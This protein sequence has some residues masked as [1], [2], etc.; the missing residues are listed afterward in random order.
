MNV[1]IILLMIIITVIKSEISDSLDEESFKLKEE[2]ISDYKENIL[3]HYLVGTSSKPV[4]LYNIDSDY[5]L[6]LTINVSQLNI[7]KLIPHLKITFLPNKITNKYLTLEQFDYSSLIETTILM[8]SD[9]A[10]IEHVL[11]LKPIEREDFRI[12]QDHK[13]KIINNK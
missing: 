8:N 5:T 10:I 7:Q 2:L 4:N 9:K 6:I 3:N 13:G 1:G 11:M 12:I